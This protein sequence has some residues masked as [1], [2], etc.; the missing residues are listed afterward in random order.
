LCTV[1]RPGGDSRLLPGQDPDASPDLAKLVPNTANMLPNEPT[2]DSA[3]L[4]SAAVTDASNPSNGYN[5]ITVDP[6]GYLFLTTTSTYFNRPAYVEVPPQT[7]CLTL[8]FKCA[9]FFFTQPDY[10]AFC[11]AGCTSCVFRDVSIDFGH[12]TA[13]GSTLPFIQLLVTGAPRGRQYDP[14]HHAAGHRWR[15]N[16]SDADTAAGKPIASHERLDAGRG[17][18]GPQ[19]PFP[20]AP[21]IFDTRTH[22]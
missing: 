1:S 4:L 9:N 20:G 13:A 18:T 3:P 2:S 15:H 22:L 17:W 14:G 12:T 11:L 16:I 10:I 7:A 8:S 6:G 19:C 21:T 5:K